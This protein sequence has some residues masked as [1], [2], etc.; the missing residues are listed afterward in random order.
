MVRSRLFLGNEKLFEVRV[1]GRAFGELFSI[2]SFF[3]FFLCKLFL[4]DIWRW[5]REFFSGEQ[6]L[7]FFSQWTK[8][9]VNLDAE[10]WNLEFFGWTKNVVWV[11]PKNS[12]FQ[13]EASRWTEYEWT[14]KQLKRIC[15]HEKKVPCRTAKC[16]KGKVNIKQKIRKK[17]GNQLPQRQVLSQST[18]KLFITQK[19]TRY[20]FP[21]RSKAQN[22]VALKKILC[23]QPNTT[24]KC[25]I[26]MEIKKG[27]P[28]GSWLPKNGNLRVWIWRQLKCLCK[29][30][31][32][33]TR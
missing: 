5:D 17:N 24:I 29:Q 11:N 13:C 20:S 16:P 2:F 10:H 18:T 21:I 31:N 32:S 22:V 6:I 1:Y 14:G 27:P 9:S 23:A 7:E 19:E 26:A 4:V 12:R 15:E 33:E 30:K 3:L 25:L 28:S 8:Y